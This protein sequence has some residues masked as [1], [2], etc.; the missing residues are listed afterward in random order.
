MSVS[1]SRGSE[2]ANTHTRRALG[3]VEQLVDE[4]LDLVRRDLRALLVDLG[5]LAGRG[6][7]HRG[8]RARLLADADEVAQHAR[9]A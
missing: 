9:A 4:Q 6:V 2:P 1:T 3:Q 7:D 8:V 5:L